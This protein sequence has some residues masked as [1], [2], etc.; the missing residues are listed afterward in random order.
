MGQEID[1][2]GS[3]YKV[4]YK[5]NPSKKEEEKNSNNID[6][7]KEKINKEQLENNKEGI[8]IEKTDDENIKKN[9]STMTVKIKIEGGF[10]EKD[11]N[12][13]TPLNQISS[14]FKEANN[15]EKIKKNHF[16]EFIYNNSPLQ[17]DSRLLNEIIDKSK[18]EI[19]IEQEMKQIPGIEKKEIIE[20]V[21]FIGKPLDNPFEIYTLDIN[22]KKISK[23]KYSK[24]K[25]RIFELNKFGINSA[26]CNGIN[27]LFIS[28]GSDPYSDEIFTIFWV[29]DLKDKIFQV[30][31]NMPIPKKN[32]RMIYIEKKVY[33]IGGNDETTL[34]YDIGKNNFI[35]WAKLK[36]KKFEPSLIKFNEYLFCID[37]SG[38]YSNDYNFEKINLIDDN[39][40]WETVNPKISPDIL[41]LNFSQKFFG[42]IED[43]NE[44]IIFVGGI[45]DNNLENNSLDKHYFNLQYNDEE[46][47]IEKSNMILKI[48]GY[49]EINLSEKSF[50]PVNENTYVIFPDFKRRA[51]K[52]LYFYKDRNSLEINS[53]RS[54]QRLTQLAN[55]TRIVSLGESMKQINL[56]MPL[57][58]SKNIYFNE[59]Y[60]TNFEK[61]DFNLLK[62]GFVPSYKYNTK[63]NLNNG[64]IKGNN[65]NINFNKKKNNMISRAYIPPKNNYINEIKREVS[66]ELFGENKNNVIISKDSNIKQENIILNQKQNI[67]EVKDNVTIEKKSS[68]GNKED[69]KN[70]NNNIEKRSDIEKKEVN[71]DEI[72]KKIEENKDNNTGRKLGDNNTN[73]KEDPKKG[74]NIESEKNENLDKINTK[75]ES[76]IKDESDKNLNKSNEIK[77]EDNDNNIKNE[78]SE[79]TMEIY[80]YDRAYSLVTFHSSVNN[81]PNYGKL[82]NNKAIKNN[83]KMKYLIKPA[84]INPKILKN[85]SR[86]FKNYEINGFNDNC[87]Y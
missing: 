71:E 12:I 27:H 81:T 37:S 74:T 40:D 69:N 46:N 54:N 18:N 39:P 73:I 47:I 8:N 51:P 55:Q 56:N 85:E 35:E 76:E 57:G 36:K 34:Y 11:Y 83:L 44:N 23:I 63:N 3:K 53:F 16:I 20:P 80:D 67:S 49:E 19:I 84:E 65:I 22:Q 70:N 1:S 43:K 6:N 68:L 48:E 66:I 64:D 45:Y 13:E 2:K 58:K 86:K 60:E 9:I 32:H 7:N 59:N 87:N 33:M 5:K 4:P 10:W 31:T 75:K 29:V 28:G 14:E 42:L 26:Y 78:K 50:L 17:M 30:R 61:N 41:N 24:E 62:S 77:K 21:D 15:L 52:V 25:E 38:K 72:S 82:S 79:T